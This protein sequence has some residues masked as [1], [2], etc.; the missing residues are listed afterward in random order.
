MKNF[1]DCLFVSLL[2]LTLV[3]CGT[4]P[5]DK[6]YHSQ[7]MWYDIRVGSTVKNDSINHELCKLAMADNLTQGVKNEDFTYQELIDQGYK[8]LGKTHTEAYVDS[9]QEVYSK[10]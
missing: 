6:K 9:L 7:T 5:L 10:P 4:R 1:A 2:V 3:A 8:L